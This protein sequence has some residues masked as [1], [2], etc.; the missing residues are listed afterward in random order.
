MIRLILLAF[1]TVLIPLSG[2]GQGYFVENKGQWPERV[3]AKTQTENGSV[4]IT[5]SGARITWLNPEDHEKLHDWLHGE[6]DGSDFMTRT[7]FDI[8]YP[9]ASPN[10]EILPSQEIGYTENYFLGKKKNWAS[11]AKAYKELLIKNFIQNIDWRLYFVD[12]AL[13]YDFIVHPGGDPN[14]I[15]WKFSDFVTVDTDDKKLEINAND[16]IFTE[17]KPYVYQVSNQRRTEVESKYKVRGDSVIFVLGDFDTSQDLIID[18][19]Y[20]FSSFTGSTADNFGYTA[21]YGPN[22]EL[23]AGGIVQG[24][25]YPLTTGV[26]NDTFNGGF[27]DVGITA[28]A[29]DGKTLVYSTYLGGIQSEQPHSMMADNQGNLFIFG[30]TSSVD[31]PVTSNAYD[32]T[33]NGGVPVSIENL[34]FASGTDIFVSKLSPDGTNLEASTYFG[35]SDNDGV[36]SNLKIQY[37]DHSKGEIYLGGD[38][39]YLSTSTKSVNIPL[40]NEYQS[41]AGPAQNALFIRFTPDLSTLE[42]ST[43]FGGAGNQGGMGC[44]LNPVTGD[45]YFVGTTTTGAFV[46]PNTNS[47]GFT[48]FGGGKD[49]FIAA[50][51]T[52]TFSLKYGTYNGTADEDQNY[53]LDID[54]EGGIYITGLTNGPYP[55]TP[56]LFGNPGSQFFHHFSHDLNTSVKSMTFGTGAVGKYDMAPTAFLIDD[57][58]NLFYSGWFGALN[59]SGALNGT[60][61]LSADAVFPTTDGEDFYFFAIGASWQQLDYATYFGGNGVKDHVDGGTSRFSKD[62]VIYQSVC[63]GCGGTSNFPVFPADVW[64][65]TNQS[66]NCNLA[67]VKIDFEPQNINLDI[68]LDPDSTCVPYMLSVKGASTN[69]DL[70]IWD[71][72]DGTPRDTTNSP[73]KLYSTPG[74]YYIKVI[75]MDT[76]CNGIDSTVLELTLYGVDLSHSPTL[77]YKKCD[78][79]F[80]VEVLDTVFS[81]N[82]IY[83]DWGDGSQNFET[84]YHNYNA[85]GAYIITYVVGD[86]LCGVYD[87]TYLNV[88][89]FDPPRGLEVNIDFPDCSNPDLLVGQ[90]SGQGYSYYVWNVEGIL[91]TGTV[92][93]KVVNRNKDLV[94][95]IYGVDSFCS[96]IDTIH[97][98]LITAEALDKKDIMPNVFTPNNDGANDYLKFINKENLLS[99]DQI[100]LQIFTRWGNKVFETGD[101][102]FLWDGTFK[103]GPLDDG[104]YMWVLTVSDNCGRGHKWSSTIHIFRK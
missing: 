49:G 66:T 86:T 78:P 77:S 46:W 75:G 4:F 62:G 25:G 83:I 30:I 67:G 6:S 85:T 63:A 58:K 51:D 38:K 9:N 60:L 88:E 102:N 50:F 100:E 29:P 12:G 57:C 99:F 37:G 10:F 61:P 47:Y 53:A 101:V 87:T 23:Y 27:M 81:K 32:T 41:T 18:P 68:Y 20:I 2:E 82:Q 72:N 69:S 70:L 92:F 43:Y 35:G 11:G 17:D 28:F 13:K 59:S 42:W 55:R 64:S 97:Y 48:Y 1:L 3:I 79:D 104:V 45:M 54:Y 16:F 95:E 89:F 74:K 21:T 19:N 91:D 14:Q 96:V 71:Y 40:V 22:G 93:Q 103:G 44:K 76:V 56:G 36:N 5:R 7:T 98:N 24:V 52:A 94:V 84:L 34:P 31:F 15:V 8:L 39:V 90:A 33:F 65:T 80:F 26:V 73:V